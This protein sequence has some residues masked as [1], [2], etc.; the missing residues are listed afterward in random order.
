MEAF[1]CGSLQGLYGSL[2]VPVSEKAFRYGISD[3]SGKALR[4]YS[5]PSCINKGS[6]RTCYPEPFPVL[7]FMRGEFVSVKNDTW[8]LPLAESRG[9][10][11]VNPRRHQVADAMNRHR[12]LVGDNGGSTAPKRPADEII[13]RTSGPLPKP[14]DTPAFPDPIP[15]LDMIVPKLLWVACFPGLGGGEISSLSHRDLIEA[16]PRIL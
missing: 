5:D 4:V 15:P 7:D 9:Y 10:R 12:G 11:E 14:I 6:K 8:G 2:D 3:A 16:S 1:S 13:V